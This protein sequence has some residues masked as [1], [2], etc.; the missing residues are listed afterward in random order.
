ME[1]E[2]LTSRY[3][4]L[5]ESSCATLYDVDI[6]YYIMIRC[7]RRTQVVRQSFGSRET[8]LRPPDICIHLDA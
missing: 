8:F 4:L 3:K 7:V 1:A 2:M 6:K 5:K